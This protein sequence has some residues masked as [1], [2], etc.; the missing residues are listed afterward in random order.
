M[1]PAPAGAIPDVSDPASAGDVMPVGRRRNP[2]TAAALSVL[3]GAG[4]LYNGQRRK[5]ATFLLTVL[6]TLGPAVLLIVSGEHL[7]TALLNDKRFA[8]F[9]LLAF[10][11]IMVF[12]ALFL[13]G[14]AFWASAVVDARR[15]ALELNRGDSV[16][17]GRWWFF[18]L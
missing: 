17:A 14:L 15:S 3:P 1:A 9:L 2:T 18:R 16:A 5:A 13:V 11:S 12:L 4:Q 6:L 10:G 7:G 8:L